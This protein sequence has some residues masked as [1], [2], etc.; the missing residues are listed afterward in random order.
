MC[1][2]VRVL[3]VPGTVPADAVRA[4]ARALPGAAPSGAALPGH[5]AAADVERYAEAGGAAVT[6]VVVPAAVSIGVD[7]LEL[8]AASG[9]PPSS[10]VLV[11]AGPPGRLPLHDAV[12]SRRRV[13]AEFAPGYERCAVLSG[14]TGAARLREAVEQARRTAAGGDPVAELAECRSAAELARARRARELRR[15]ESRRIIG[16]L[17]A[18]RDGLVRRRA[19]LRSEDGLPARMSAVRTELSRV[20]VEL[21]HE[22]AAVG[23]RTAAEAR[24]ELDGAGRAETE[25]FPVRLEQRLAVAGGGFA[26]RVDARLAAVAPGSVPDGGPGAVQDGAPDTVA[27]PSLPTAPGRGRRAVEDRLMIL[28]GASGGLG[29]GRLVTAGPLAGLLGPGPWAA[30]AWPVTLALGGLAAWWIV[31]A[32][33]HLARRARLK[34]WAAEAVAEFRAGW[35]RRL[36]HRVLDA[37]AHAAHAVGAAHARELRAVEAELARVDAELTG[38]RAHARGRPGVPAAQPVDNPHAGP[39]PAVP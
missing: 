39:G 25:S 17:R 36:A 31:R 20:R 16:A 7:E 2:E 18:R 35:E 37:E 11:A 13:L 12:E 21:G 4:V 28:M 9:A 38:M 1:E 26:R 10:V 34:Q 32:R 23:R 15:A 33:A 22:I 19:G 24:A 5:E 27:G 30:L 29:L 6:V 8:I 14:G 3:A